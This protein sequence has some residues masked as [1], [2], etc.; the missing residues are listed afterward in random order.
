MSDVDVEVK[1]AADT[2]TRT[3]YRLAATNCVPMPPIFHKVCV[4]SPLNGAFKGMTSSS[5][6][7]SGALMA[8]ADLSVHVEFA[9]FALK[10]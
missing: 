2:V 1:V 8:G 3:T 7:T 4:P 9:G 10:I 6:A 5:E